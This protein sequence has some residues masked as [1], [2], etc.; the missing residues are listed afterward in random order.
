MIVN[1]QQKTKCNKIQVY[2]G[3]TEVANRYNP[4]TCTSESS[5]AHIQK[6]KRFKAQQIAETMCKT[7]QQTNYK[8]ICFGTAIL[9]FR[10]TCFIPQ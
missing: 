10:Y 8:H 7:W 5:Q 1:G 2:G 3:I 6:D 4:N 9:R